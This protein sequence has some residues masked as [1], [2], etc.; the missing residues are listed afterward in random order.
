MFIFWRYLFK[1]APKVWKTLLPEPSETFTPHLTP[2]WCRW[3]HADGTSGDLDPQLTFTS[4]LIRPLTRPHPRRWCGPAGQSWPC[5]RRGP[6][7][8][9]P[10]HCCP[11]RLPA[12][13]P[14]WVL[15][16]GGNREMGQA[17]HPSIKVCHWTK[18]HSG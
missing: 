10:A 14:A 4:A 16:A 11:A 7:R 9:L 1:S 8:S 5:R 2:A 3:C 18:S 17:A 12:H 15:A 13:L 6:G